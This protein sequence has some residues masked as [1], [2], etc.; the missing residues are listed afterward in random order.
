MLI[1]KTQIG[2]WCLNIRLFDNRD[3]LVFKFFKSNLSDYQ[4]CFVVLFLS[5]LDKINFLR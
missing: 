5:N 1:Y 2:S 4:R 3:G